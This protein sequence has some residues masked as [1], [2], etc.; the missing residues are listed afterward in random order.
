VSEVTGQQPPERQS[1]E[2]ERAG[3]II[4]VTAGCGLDWTG[5]RRAWDVWFSDRHAWAH[6]KGRDGLSAS[7][8]G[9]AITIVEP[10]PEPAEQPGSGSTGRRG[11]IPRQYPADAVAG[12][13]DMPRQASPEPE[14]DALMAGHEPPE[15]VIRAEL[16]ADL[17]SARQA[18][19]AI[20]QALAAWGM[21]RLSDDAELLGSELV[22]NAAE[23]G[24]GKPIGLALRR[25]AEPDGRPGVTCEVTD[26]AH[27]CVPRLVPGPD[28]E[29]GRG[30]AI[31]ATLADS[32]GVRTSQAGKTSWF[33]L[34][35]TDR[36]HRIASQI[37]HEREAG[38]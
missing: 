35:L 10:G 15:G 31:V 5:P 34:A 14:A 1:S 28:A 4:H 23:H 32:S 24:D 18:R 36:A 30:L 38:S 2:A 12:P 17:T 33:T 7:C 25:H 16:S 8:S 26:S 27:Q 37:E 3:D 21:D 11:S 29:R 20:R 19:A 6:N 9:T 13:A 22:A